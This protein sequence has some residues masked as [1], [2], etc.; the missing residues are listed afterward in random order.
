MKVGQDVLYLKILV[1]KEGKSDT[2]YDH[3]DAG[4]S[5]NDKKCFKRPIFMFTSAN[6]EK[7]DQ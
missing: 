4:L 2:A 3:S 5:K 7:P 1:C 6:M